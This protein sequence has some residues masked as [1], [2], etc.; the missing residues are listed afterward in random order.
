MSLRGV[1]QTAMIDA[2]GNLAKEWRIFFSLI[3]KDVAGWQPPTFA[4]ADAPK[5]TIYYSTTATKLVYKTAA[6]VVNALY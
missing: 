6:G 1:P 5:N 4:D 2:N 3:A